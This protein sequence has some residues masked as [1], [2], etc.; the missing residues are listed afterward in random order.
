MKEFHVTTKNN[1]KFKIL[2]QPDDPICNRLSIGGIKDKG[3][4]ITYRG[5]INTCVEILEEALAAFKKAQE[6]N[7][8]QNN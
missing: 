7:Q 5:D 3:C 2:K 6:V 4:Y 8:T 1:Y